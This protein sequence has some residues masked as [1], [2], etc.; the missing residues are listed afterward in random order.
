MKLKKIK[1]ISKEQLTQ[2][3]YKHD[4]MKLVGMGC[5]EDEY[6]YEARLILQH[7]PSQMMFFRHIGEEYTVEHIHAIV[8]WVFEFAFERCS[9]GDVEQYKAIAEDIKNE[10]GSV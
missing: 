7:M 1:M 9:I 4:P 3:L 2:L 5:P 6:E 8:Y 10:F